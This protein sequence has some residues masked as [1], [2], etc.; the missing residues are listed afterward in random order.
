MLKMDKKL[1]EKFR[2]SKGISLVSG[3]FVEWELGDKDIVL[4]GHFTLDELE[5][6]VQIVREIMASESKAP[7]GN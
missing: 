3:T 7:S 2:T 4:D 6:I 5:L 1:L